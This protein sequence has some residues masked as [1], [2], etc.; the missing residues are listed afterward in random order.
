MLPLARGMARPLPARAVERRLHHR[1]I[2]EDAAG[3]RR[4]GSLRAPHHRPG[5]QRRIAGCL[6]GHQ[7][8]GGQGDRPALRAHQASLLGGRQGV[9]G[10]RAMRPGARS[11]RVGGGLLLRRRELPRRC[12]GLHLVASREPVGKLPRLRPTPAGCAPQAEPCGH[13]GPANDHDHRLHRPAHLLL[14]GD[15]L[16][17]VRAGASPGASSGGRASRQPSRPPPQQPSCLCSIRRH[18][19]QHRANGARA[20]ELRLSAN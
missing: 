11:L 4:A 19:S 2:R 15:V 17:A 5:R 8:D 13:L 1:C 20:L 18:A 10:G 7:S 16:H 6:L 14:R 9:R 12:G 3:Q